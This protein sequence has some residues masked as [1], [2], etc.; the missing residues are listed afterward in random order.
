MIP[1]G[2]ANELS[3]IFQQPLTSGDQEIATRHVEGLDAMETVLDAAQPASGLTFY[4]AARGGC[5][6][7][8]GN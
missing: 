4:E 2:N 6:I 5:G 8:P 3:E 1:P 7:S